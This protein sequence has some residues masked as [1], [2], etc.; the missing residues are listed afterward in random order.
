MIRNASL[1]DRFSL[2]RAARLAVLLLPLAAGCAKA[3]G[4]VGEARDA[5]PLPAP[6]S[7]A[8][9]AR[10]VQEGAPAPEITFTLH[11]GFALTLTSLRGKVVEVLFCP[12]GAAP[13]DCTIEADGIRDH[14]SDLQAHGVAVVGVRAAA[15]VSNRLL[16]S[17]ERLPFDFA[18]DPDGRI[19]GAFGVDLGE[20][21]APRI[22]MIGRDGR[23]RKIWRAADPA[24]HV[25]ALLATN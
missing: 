21:R 25:S 4:D 16:M 6:P 10:T 23:V 9:A 17:Q 8:A 20:L 19:A 11:D 15:V 2:R 24:A 5:G 22:F 13:A 18:S 12:T 14:W 3:R 7:P 1:F